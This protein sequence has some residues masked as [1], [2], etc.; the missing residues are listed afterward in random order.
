MA[1][2]LGVVVTLR[3]SSC[4]AEGANVAAEEQYV[5]SNFV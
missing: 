3:G 5:E 2:G 4:N 1:E